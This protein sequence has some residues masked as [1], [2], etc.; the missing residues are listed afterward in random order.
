MRTT[1]AKPDRDPTVHVTLTE[2]IM[3]T[4]AAR[5]TTIKLPCK[6]VHRAYNG[7]VPSEKRRFLVAA[8]EMYNLDTDK[9]KP[10]LGMAALLVM[11][12]GKVRND[13]FVFVVV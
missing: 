10:V 6:K 4:G 7:M 1:M 9:G 13:D 2:T 11:S 5:E 8:Q 3:S 12:G